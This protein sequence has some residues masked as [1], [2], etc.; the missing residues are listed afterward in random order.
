MRYVKC[1]TTKPGLFENSSLDFSP[2]VTIVNGKNG[3]GKSFMARCLIESLW[4]S[5]EAP[6]LL[7]NSAWDSMFF[8]VSINLANGKGIE[9]RYRFTHNGQSFSIAHENGSTTE[10]VTHDGSEEQDL[11]RRISEMEEGN[12][13]SHFWEN[14]NLTSFINSSFVPSPSDLESEEVLHFDTI[15]KLI[16]SDSGGFYDLAGMLKRRFGPDADEGRLALLIDETE[17]ELKDLQKQIELI[18]IK[19]M[20]S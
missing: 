10:L 1:V 2:A 15:K 4:K 14:I 7:W 9:N 3:S 11:L 5:I 6:R 8:D 13:L 18:R 16:L 19:G 12:I 17:A 20:R